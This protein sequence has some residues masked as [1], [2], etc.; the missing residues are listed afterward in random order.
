MF[1]NRPTRSF[2]K[3]LKNA[4]PDFKQGWNDGCNV[5]MTAGSN[6]FY[7]SFY[8]SNQVDGYKITN[9]PEYSTAYNN[10]FWFCYRTDYIKQKSTIWG[11]FFKGHI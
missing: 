7:K 11:S 8:S 5:G 9:S 10:A 2:K 6:T 3:E 4:S 1:P